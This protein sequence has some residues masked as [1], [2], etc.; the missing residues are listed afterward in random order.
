[1]GHGVGSLHR[2]LW[3]KPTD[4]PDPPNRAPVATASIP[5]ATV[6]VGDSLLLDLETYF[7]D[8]DG[9]NLSYAAI[10]SDANVATAS[11]SASTAKV[12]ALARGTASV[13]VTA[14]DP[15]GLA[16]SQSFA[17]TVPNRP[18]VVSDSIPERELSVGDSLLLDLTAY[19][20]DPDG[21]GLSY[22][23]ISSDANVATASVS[24]SVVTVMA[25]APGAATITVTASDPSGLRSRSISVSR[26]WLGRSRRSSQHPI[27]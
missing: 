8:P 27:P 17:V 4:P 24:G 19:F 14:T 16:A 1:M 26:P 5:S 3:R 2:S 18:P 15:D 12:M 21:D 9:D 25:L 22:A 23:A 11:V 6:Q 20:S 13:T 10:S 7:S